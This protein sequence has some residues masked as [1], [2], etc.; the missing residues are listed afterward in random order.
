M[1]ILENDVPDKCVARVSG[2]TFRDAYGDFSLEDEC[3]WEE[4]EHNPQK[5]TEN[6]KYD[7]LVLNKKKGKQTQVFLV[8][9]RVVC[10]FKHNNV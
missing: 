9:L 6:R 7:M 1:R 10:F 2:T 8:E 4:Y 3:E 5:L